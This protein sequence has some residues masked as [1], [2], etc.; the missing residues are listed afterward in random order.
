VTS[1]RT[2]ASPPSGSGLGPNLPY[3]VTIVVSLVLLVGYIAVGKPFTP[4]GGASD[5][6]TTTA[7]SATGDTTTTTAVTTSSIAGET[8]TTVPG[9]S[10]AL[11]E[12]IFNGT[13]IAC[14]GVGAVGVVGLGPALTTSEFVAGLTDDE[15]VAF[16]IVGR[17][18]TD[19]ANTTGISMPPRGGNASLTDDDLRAVVAYLRDLQIP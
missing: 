14:H 13:C 16:L 1:G 15:L 2:G 5:A 18:D 3:V 9:G 8:T 17:P 4:S 11:G 10:L 6:T 12:E 7:G 19:P